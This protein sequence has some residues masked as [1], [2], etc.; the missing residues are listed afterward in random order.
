MVVLCNFTPVPRP[1]WHCGMPRAGRW[2]EALNTDAGIYGGSNT[3]NMGTVIAGGEGWH[4]QPVSAHVTIPPLST[5][6]L[7]W[8]GD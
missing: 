4:G 6:F 7:T 3:G 1:G 2:R 5:V 8:D